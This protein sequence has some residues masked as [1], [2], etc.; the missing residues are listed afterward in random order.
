MVG[1]DIALSMSQIELSKTNDLCEIEILEIELFDNF[2]C[3]STKY[4]Y[5]HN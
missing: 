2:M 5:K 3:V 1:P 4:V